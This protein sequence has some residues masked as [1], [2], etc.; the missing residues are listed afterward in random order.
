MK[1]CSSRNCRRTGL[2]E[3]HQV[4]MMPSPRHQES[5]V[6]VLPKLLQTPP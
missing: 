2:P 4:P 1:D 6:R 5:H 3:A